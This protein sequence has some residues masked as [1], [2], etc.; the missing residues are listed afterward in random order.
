MNFVLS[1]SRSVR[2]GRFRRRSLAGQDAALS[3]PGRVGSGSSPPGEGAYKGALD[4]PG[5]GLARPETRS[6]PAWV[7]IVAEPTARVRAKALKAHVLG[8]APRSRCRNARS[9][10]QGAARGARRSPHLRTPPFPTLP[11]ARPAGA[12]R[13]NAPRAPLNFRSAAPFMPRADSAART[14][15]HVFPLVIA[16]PG[17]RGCEPALACV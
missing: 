15:A 5:G 1:R 6:A 8:V 10:D 9:R 11:F 7:P 12:R 3:P 13:P 2:E 16:R 17:R 4:R 14:M